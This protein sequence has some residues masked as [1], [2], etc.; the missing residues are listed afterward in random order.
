MKSV[1]RIAGL[2]EFGAVR[3]SDAARRGRQ[4]ARPATARRAVRSGAPQLAPEA[5][6]ETFLRRVSLDLVGRQP[7][8]ED[9]TTFSLDRDPA[10]REKLIEKLL[11]SEKYGT[12]WSRYWRDVIMYRKTEQRRRSLSQPLQEY[13]TKKLNDDAPWS[14]VATSF[15]TAVGDIKEN[16]NA[17]LIVAQEG[18]PEETV[19]E[20]SRH[21]PGDQHPMCPVPRS[22]HRSLECEQFHELAAL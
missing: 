2:F 14:E 11:G 9:V 5:D 7:L 8:P 13:L 22:S 12:N 19:A 16:G 21:L 18:K 20:I 6:D 4:R 17:A 15:I 3:R 1:R 10:K